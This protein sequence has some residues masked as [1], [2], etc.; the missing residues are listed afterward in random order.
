MRDFQKKSKPAQGV[1]MKFNE[2]KL[3]W[4]HGINNKIRKNTFLSEQTKR[5]SGTL[6]NFKQNFDFKFKQFKQFEEFK[7]NFKK[8]INPINSIVAI[9]VSCS[10]FIGLMSVNTQDVFKKNEELIKRSQHE[11][12]LYEMAFEKKPP[13]YPMEKL[14]KLEKNLSIFPLMTKYDLVVNSEVVAS[15]PDVETPKAVLAELLSLSDEAD[16]EDVKYSYDEK[17]HIIQKIVPLY[18]VTSL[19]GFESALNYIKS[20]QKEAVR[21]TVVKG[22]YVEKIA[23]K[24]GVTPKDLIEVNPD[25]L[26]KKYLQIGDELLIMKSN[27]LINARLSYVQEYTEAIEPEVEIKENASMYE[28]EKKTLEEGSDGEQKV[29][30]RIIKKNGFILE[31]QILNSEVLSTPTKK[32]VMVGTKKMPIRLVSSAVQSRSRSY[33]V[34]Q[35]ELRGGLKLQS[36]MASYLITSRYGGRSGGFHHGID[37]A[38][39]S[40][41][42]VYAAESGVVTVSTT[43]GR[44]YGHYIKINHGSGVST[45][46]A[47]CS[48]LLVE[49]GQKVEKGQLIAKSGNTG[50]S[51]GPHL[52]FEVLIDG[53]SQN[54]ERFCR[55]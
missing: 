13:V 42:P 33:G 45:I 41:T 3:K 17:V 29:V 12:M 20:G 19:D 48:S 34:E 27:P 7:Q 39:P 51:T 35:K 40:G 47:H 10:F 30:A 53:N 1:A 46:Y 18:E 2:L 32:V 44:G 55:F 37:L 14:A 11:G 6:K 50:K 49:T 23:A 38:T 26:S 15:F 25:V 4:K 16:Y 43:R 21:Y 36:P 31:K 5:L 22:D 9:S 54:P 24:F 8:H 52:H 28:G